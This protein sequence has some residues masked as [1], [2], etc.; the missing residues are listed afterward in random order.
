MKNYSNVINLI[1]FMAISG[2]CVVN[3]SFISVPAE[4]ASIQDAL[5]SAE[6]ADVILVES[7]TYYENIRWPQQDGIVLKSASGPFNTVI[8]AGSKGRVVTFPEG[9]SRETVL[10][11]FTLINGNVAGYGGGIFIAST[12]PTVRNNRI[13]HCNAMGDNKIKE[14]QNANGGFINHQGGGAIFC[15]YS[16]ACIINNWIEDCRGLVGGG[17]YNFS[18]SSLIKG[19]FITGCWSKNGGG[20]VFSLYEP[21]G[22]IIDNT[23]MG[24]ESRY[25]GGIFCMVN[26]APLIR[27]NR[28]ISNQAEMGGGGISVSSSRPWIENNL[29]D[30]NVSHG[31]AGGIGIFNSWP[32]I[33]GNTFVNNRASGT[34]SALK[35]DNANNN[36]SP[37]INNNIFSGNRSDQGPGVMI[38]GDCDHQLTYNLFWNNIPENLPAPLVENL[39]RSNMS[40]NP[41][42]T[43]G[44]ESGYYLAHRETGQSFDSA[45]IN[46]GHPLVLPVGSTRIDGVADKD[47]CDLGYH[48]HSCHKLLTGVK[49]TSGTS[50]FIPGDELQVQCKLKNTTDYPLTV[51]LLVMVQLEGMYFYLPGWSSEYLTEKTTLTDREERDINILSVTMPDVSDCHTLSVYAVLLESGSDAIISNVS[52]IHVSLN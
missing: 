21:G 34:G 33:C 44:S 2:F 32:L 41:G 12:D 18:S 6:T 38:S 27:G 22:I 52:S 26:S 37:M 13:S 14:K 28:I 7:G 8:D 24:N 46:R 43:M 10:E 9:L 36:F 48:S 19:N 51:E 40:L 30:G 49:L 42:F 1:F 5:D 29:I 31:D 50:Q 39:M 16:K 3:A 45:C 35:L 11:G 17:I 20:A 15:R 23:M 47:V 25:G 4:Y